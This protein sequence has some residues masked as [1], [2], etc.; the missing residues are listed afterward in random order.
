MAE[1]MASVIDESGASANIAGALH[2]A[3][4][5]FLELVFLFEG[6][7]P[8]QISLGG[9][10]RYGFRMF[11]AHGFRVALSREFFKMVPSRLNIPPPRGLQSGGHP[12]CVSGR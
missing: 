10:Q 4:E 2:A 9:S 8:E 1:H 7:F 6:Q 12:G 3:E 5:V 11:H